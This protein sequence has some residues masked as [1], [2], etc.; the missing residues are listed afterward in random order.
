[1]SVRIYELSVMNYR[2][3]Y[4]FFRGPGVTLRNGTLS[5]A[6]QSASIVFTS[7]KSIE[8]SMFDQAI[9][10]DTI[11]DTRIIIYYERD[12]FHEFLEILRNEKP[13]KFRVKYEHPHYTTI[14]ELN[15]NL[16]RYKISDAFLWSQD[17]PVGENESI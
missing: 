5:S 14:T 6:T 17:E 2:I 1:M 13:L 3:S 4:H 12:R 8:D 7:E 10:N 11:T 9:E 16:N 15:Q